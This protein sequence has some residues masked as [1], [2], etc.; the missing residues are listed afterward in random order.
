M[1]IFLSPAKRLNTDEIEKQW[2]KETQPR[3]LKDAEQLMEILK[4]KTPK[5]L[6][7]LMSI[8]DDIAQMNY[9]RNQH[10]TAKPK[11]DNGYQ[12]GLMF[13]GEV[14]RGLRDTP[15]SSEAVEYLKE[16]VYILSGLYG[17]LSPLDVVMPYRLEM[18]TKLQNPDGKTLY[19]FW[20]KRLTDF[21]NKNT[22]K[23]EILLDLSSKE[24]MKSLLHDELKGTLIDVKF[25]DYKNGKLKQINVYFKKA[26]GAMARFCAENQVQNLDDLKAFTGMNYAYDDNLSSERELVFVR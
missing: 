19:D 26:R 6:S 3:F 20:Q 22:K 10:W 1:K 9:E 7:D 12:A 2:G 4:T 17:I 23:G 18:G 25:K 5:Q 8:S 11:K 15:L 24:Y 16:H 14:Y 13:D 21:V